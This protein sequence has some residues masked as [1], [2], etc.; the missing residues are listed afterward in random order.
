MVES[1][2]KVPLEEII[3]SKITEASLKKLFI[4]INFPVIFPVIMSQK[5]LGT[6]GP[7]W[8][9]NMWK[10]KLQKLV[11]AVISKISIF[12]SRISGSFISY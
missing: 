1:F 3:F 8:L 6:L 7:I 2:E 4:T 11:F 5:S 12:Q 10:I 9:I